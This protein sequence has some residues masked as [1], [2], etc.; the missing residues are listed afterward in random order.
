MMYVNLLMVVVC[1]GV[2]RYAWHKTTPYMTIAMIVF[3]T[4]N[5]MCF[6]VQMFEGA[7]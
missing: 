5:L 7:S 6:A 2:A 3:G 1:F 4:L